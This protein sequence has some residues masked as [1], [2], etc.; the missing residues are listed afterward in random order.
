MTVIAG[1]SV[2][3]IIE[4]GKHRDSALD[5]VLEAALGFKTAGQEG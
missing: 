3:A 1:K 5:A 2:T 4:A